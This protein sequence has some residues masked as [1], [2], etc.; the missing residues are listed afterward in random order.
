MVTKHIQ[1]ANMSKETEA[2]ILSAVRTPSGK[3]Q[4]AL[5]G[6]PAPKLGAIAVK[7]AVE[8]AGIDPKDVEEVL[9]GNVVQAGLG[10]APARQAGIFGGIPNTVGATTVNKVCGSSLKAAMM[11]AQAIRAGDGD[12]FIAGGFESMS[13]APYLVNGRLGELKFGNQQ[14]TDALLNDGLW[15]PFENWVMG[16]AAEFIADE[17]EV[18]RE[19]MD[20]FAFESHQKAVAAQETGKFKDE[21]VPVQ[22]PGRKG[23]VTVVSQDEGPRKDTSIE[24][25]AKLKPAF[26]TDG[27]VTPGNASTMNDGA[28]AV[29]ISSRA[30][31]ESHKLKPLAKVVGYA[32]AA[33]EPKY[34]FAAPAYAIPKLLKKIDWK[35]SDVD[36]FEVNEA[37]AAQVLADGYMLA[38]QGWDWDKVN[39]NGGAIALGHPLGA[40]G[41]R[42]LTTLIHALKGRG[43]KRGIASLCLGGGEAVA[44]AVESE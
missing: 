14:M 7:A 13:R 16:M 6:I 31:A 19:A 21:I 24:S 18:T 20:K 11:C 2:I 33:L 12:L 30:Y 15:D 34:L 43:L 8:R 9:M 22:I 39:V 44:M 37:F 25:L 40:S 10:Q 26:K 1:G 36:L 23:E 42:V 32:Q 29:V 3:F 5:S 28:A 35:L 27:K 4:G 38:D 17:H 41:A